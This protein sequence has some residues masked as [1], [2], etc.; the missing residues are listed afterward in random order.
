M[1]NTAFSYVFMKLTKRISKQLRYLQES[2]NS[3]DI[4]EK[5]IGIASFILMASCFLPWYYGPTFEASVYKFGYDYVNFNG[6]QSY[7]YI[8]GYLIFFCAGVTMYY[9]LANLFDWKRFKLPI[10]E[11]QI[12][13]Y[14]GERILLF[15]ILALFIYTKQSFYYTQAEVR[16]GVYLGTVAALLVLSF[17]YLHN[18]SA[19]E[20]SEKQKLRNR[21][22]STFR[23]EMDA[24][25]EQNEAQAP[26]AQPYRP[27]LDV[28]AKAKQNMNAE[29]SEEHQLHS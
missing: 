21:L 6:F 14:M 2:F 25:A 8:L 18:K 4:E 15:E 17:G 5:I 3:L 16:F 24:N 20:K 13:M 1:L 19:H 23:E 9:F 26:A 10:P 28:L 7:G 12:Y 11:R 27:G 22:E 29:R